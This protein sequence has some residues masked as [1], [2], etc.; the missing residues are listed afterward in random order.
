MELKAHQR[1]GVG[2]MGQTACPWERI[3]PTGPLPRPMHRGGSLGPDA[4]APPMC[5]SARGSVKCIWG[6]DVVVLGLLMT[7]GGSHRCPVY[8]CSVM[9]PGGGRRMHMGNFL[10]ESLVLCLGG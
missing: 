10:I 8:E 9:G 7:F 1:L 3:C 4:G 2:R 5:G 6:S